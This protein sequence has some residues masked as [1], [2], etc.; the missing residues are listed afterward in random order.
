MKKTKPDATDMGKMEKMRK[1][2]KQKLVIWATEHEGQWEKGWRAN[3]SALMEVEGGC[4][5]KTPKEWLVAV[6]TRDNK[7]KT[8]E[9]NVDLQKI[10]R[11]RPGGAG[12]HT[13]EE[14]SLASDKAMG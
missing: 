7:Y 9:E 10:K 6:E 13:S 5:P 3:E 12:D 2:L 11:R 4:P 8:V 1:A 14:R